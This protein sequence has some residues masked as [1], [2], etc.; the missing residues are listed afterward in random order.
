MSLRFLDMILLIFTP[1]KYFKFPIESNYRCCLNNKDISVQFI[2]AYQPTR[3]NLLYNQHCIVKTIYSHNRYHLFWIL[4]MSRHF[5]ETF[6]SGESLQ[7]MLT[8]GNWQGSNFKCGS[9]ILLHTTRQGIG[10][11]GE[12]HPIAILLK[13]SWLI[14]NTWMNVLAM[15]YCFMQN[16]IIHMK[17]KL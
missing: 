11:T 10:L 2:R 7:K 14:Y 8:G 5:H 6:T 15:M 16:Q 3:H 9:M 17:Y 4:L 13:I 12:L 1:S